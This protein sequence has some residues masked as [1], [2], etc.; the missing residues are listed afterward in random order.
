MARSRFMP[1]DADTVHPAASLRDE[2]TAALSARRELGE[3]LEPEV[4][5]AFLARVERTAAARTRDE[6]ATAA[7]HQR[8]MDRLKWSLG[9][10]T[11]LVVVSTWAGSEAAGGLGGIVGLLGSLAV[12]LVANV[13]PTEVEK[14]MEKERLMRR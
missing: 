12:V 10:G 11:P 7:W 5:D 9:L 13:Y 1:R 2:L 14:E 3:A 6:T 8:M 4:I